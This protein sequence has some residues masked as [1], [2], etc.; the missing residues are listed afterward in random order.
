LRNITYTDSAG[1]EVLRNI[2]SQS[3]ADLVTST[4]W[5]QYL[6][7]EITANREEENDQEAHNATNA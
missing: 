5:S 6:A 3:R 1:K 7:T 2:Y 4:P